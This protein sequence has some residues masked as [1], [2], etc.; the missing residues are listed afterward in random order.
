Y[1]VSAV[2]PVGAPQ[3]IADPAFDS[4]RPPLSYLWDV[5]PLGRPPVAQTFHPVGEPGKV[6]TVVNN[7][8][9]SKGSSCAS[10]GDPFDVHQANCNLTRMAQAEALMAFVADLQA[11]TGDPD[12]LIVGDLNSYAK[13]D[14][15]DR[16]KLGPDGMQGGGDN[17][18]DLINKPGSNTAY[19]YVFDGQLGT[20]DYALA[21]ASLLS[22]VR[23]VTMFHI[24]ADEPDIL[25]YDTSFKKPAQAALFEPLPYRVS[26]HDPVIVGLVLRG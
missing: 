23:G 4:V 6:F 7:H 16:I 5:E 21:S 9:K 22:Q 14:P 13:E 12:V 25:D 8:F 18:F 19:G 3:T 11:S 2:V 17:F 24:N 1:R 10:V 20:L 26:D 15:I